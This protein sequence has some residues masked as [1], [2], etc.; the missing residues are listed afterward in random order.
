MVVIRNRK[1]PK[2]RNRLSQKKRRQWNVREKLMLHPGK[3]AK[4]SDIEDDLFTWVCKRRTNQNPVT[5][6]MITKKAITL[7]RNQ[8]FLANNPNIT[9]F[10]F[11][12][13]WLSGF[14][15]RYNLSERHR[16]TVAQQ[17]PSDLIEKQ[18]HDYP[19]KYIGNIDETLL[20]FDLPS[21][22]TID[23]KGTKTVSIH[24]TGHECSS[25][26][27]VLACIADGSKLLAVCI[28]KLKNV[29]KENFPYGIHIRANEKGWMNEK[30]MLWWIET[31]WTS[32]NPFGNS[33]SLL[34]LDSFRGHIVSSV[35]NRLVEKN[36]N[37]AVIPGGCTSKLQPLDV[38]I[39][40]S[41]K[42]KMSST[43]HTLTPAGRI[44][45][46]SYST[47][48]TW[49]KESWD[50]V[51]K[52]LIRRSFKCCGVSTNTDGSK[53]NDLFDYDKLLGM[54]EDDDESKENN[55][56]NNSSGEDGNQNQELT[57]DEE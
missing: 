21:N 10:K 20:W 25:F 43:I 23:H 26:T 27:V 36:T 34:V 1:N 29:P 2:A 24:T 56:G 8:D 33:R 44:K 37:I 7:S 48:A 3:S 47:V 45:K 32:R 52:D 39:N 19:L 14:L 22:F 38:A 13:K 46:P 12:N 5:R 18:N 30:E 9:S 15:G 17:L 28:F 35:K 51:D 40:K 6:K 41:F 49:V 42:A 55:G 57:S 31:V 50:D 54:P 11:S 4:Y 53:D 16:T